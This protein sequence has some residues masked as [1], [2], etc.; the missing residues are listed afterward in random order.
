MLCTRALTHALH[1]HSTRFHKH[2]LHVLYTHY[3]SEISIKHSFVV[4]QVE[5]FFTYFFFKTSSLTLLKSGDRVQIAQDVFLSLNSDRMELLGR[6]ILVKYAIARYSL[7][8][9]KFKKVFLGLRT[10]DSFPLFR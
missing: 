10:L 6:E 3:M 9:Y 4:Y 8:V 7:K 2:A 1:A 5:R